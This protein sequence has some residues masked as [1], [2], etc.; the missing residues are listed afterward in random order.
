MLASKHWLLHVH[1]QLQ[2]CIALKRST[3]VDNRQRQQQ[4]QSLAGAKQQGAQHFTSTPSPATATA[5]EPVLPLPVVRRCCHRHRLISAGVGHAK[6]LQLQARDK[7][8]LRYVSIDTARLIYTEPTQQ[9]PA[10]QYFLGCTQ[11]HPALAAAAAHE[12]K[13]RQH[14]ASW[15]PIHTL[16]HLLPHLCKVV[17]PEVASLVHQLRGKAAVQQQA[18]LAQAM[19]VWVTT[20]S[21]QAA[22]VAA[23]WRYIPAQAV[24]LSSGDT[25]THNTAV[26]RHLL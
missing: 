6:R 5:A 17:L 25:N 16:T 13:V 24:H 1:V 23:G 22:V 18:K 7:N 11:Q 10:G 8:V 2:Q 15:Q 21:A 9:H 4:Q 3:T 26:H 20:P 12:G 19:Q 14:A